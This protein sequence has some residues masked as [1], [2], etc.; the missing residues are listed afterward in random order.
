ML[1]LNNEKQELAGHGASLKKKVQR[2]DPLGR[3]SEA[4]AAC[5]QQ[6]SEIVGRW[7]YKYPHDKNQLAR[8]HNSAFAAIINRSGGEFT[9][10]GRDGPIKYN[11]ME[12]MYVPDNGVS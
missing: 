6:C 7:V 3:K 11:W 10:H 1:T 12:D 9:C 8:I 4:L 5:G 2:C